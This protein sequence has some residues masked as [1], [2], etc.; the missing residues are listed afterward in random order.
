MEEERR[1]AYV[2]M[3]RAKEELILTYAT[4]R[5]LYGSLQYNLPSQFLADVDSSS[6]RPS[7]GS[8][9]MSINQPDQPRYAPDLN[10]GDTV[11]HNVFGIGVVLEVHGDV[12]AINFKDKGIKKL[13]TGFAPLEKLE[14]NA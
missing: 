7:L 11:R 10:E 8:E 6:T 9:G 3:T 14:D 5:A 1:L 2:G 12:V 13:N 4:S